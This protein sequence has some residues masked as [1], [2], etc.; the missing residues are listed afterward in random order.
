MNFRYA[1][2]VLFLSLS[3]PIVAFAHTGGIDE[4]L[5]RAPMGVSKTIL[6]RHVRFSEYRKPISGGAFRLASAASGLNNRTVIGFSSNT[7]RPKRLR[8]LLESNL[9]DVSEFVVIDFPSVELK[10]TFERAIEM[11]KPRPHIYGFEQQWAPESLHKKTVSRMPFGKPED[12]LLTLTIETAIAQ[13]D[14]GPQMLGYYLVGNDY[15]PSLVINRSE[16]EPPQELTGPKSYSSLFYYLQTQLEQD[17][18]KRR[19][20]RQILAPITPENHAPFLL[21]RLCDALLNTQLR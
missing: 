8:L 17:G 21:V 15:Q 18:E 2:K 20:Q 16:L 11:D 9:A 6:N 19:K 14:E 10:M 7:H 13:T 3:T 12:K 4:D 5:T 1:A